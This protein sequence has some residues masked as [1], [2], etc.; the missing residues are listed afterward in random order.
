MIYTHC[1]KCIDCKRFS[2]L[3]HAYMWCKMWLLYLCW[4]QRPNF[5][6]TCISFPSGQQLFLPPLSQVYFNHCQ[7]FSG[8]G[9]PTTR[10]KD[11]AW[12]NPTCW[13][14]FPWHQLLVYGLEALQ[15]IIDIWGLVFCG[16]I[17]IFQWH[18]IEVHIIY[19]LTFTNSFCREWKEHSN[20]AIVFYFTF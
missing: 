14:L 20:S 15:P 12:S 1:Q 17:S 7:D 8:S 5:S 3:L 9:L 13:S 10:T 19:R 6:F 4:E 16:I 11:Q 18:H 2:I